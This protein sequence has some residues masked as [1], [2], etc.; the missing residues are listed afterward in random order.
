MISRGLFI[1][2][3]D[4]GVGKTFVARGVLRALKEAGMRVCPLK[5][6][7]SGCRSSKGVLVPRDAA[8]LMRVAGIREPLD[9]IN[10]YRFRQALAP[11][12]AAELEHVRVSRKKI[13][14][15]YR[16]LS[17]KYD[18][19]VVEGAGGIM[20]PLSRNYLFID[21]ARDLGLPVIIVS[22]PGLGTINHTL[23]TVEALRTRGLEIAGVIIN[24]AEGTRH[25]LSG[26]TNPGVIERL[27][28]VRLLGIIPHLTSLKSGSECFL[29]IA[30][31][32]FGQGGRITS[33]Q[34]NIRVSRK[35]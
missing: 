24:D 22:R 5:P 34:V 10:P 8:A 15:A 14:D 26:R 29:G 3:T 7:E 23:L 6:A 33:A 31:R 35:N 11:A 9:V 28:A 21:L 13:L 25:G 16:R 1:T 4:T 19:T 30:K 18:M 12:V 27:G 20:V 17:L 2:G 32:L